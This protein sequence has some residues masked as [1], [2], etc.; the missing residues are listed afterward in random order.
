MYSGILQILN[1]YVQKCLEISVQSVYRRSA[2]YK[3]KS[4]DVNCAVNYFR[5][6]SGLKEQNI[7]FIGYKYIHFQSRTFLLIKILK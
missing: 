3:I 4:E 6:G 1:V 2:A 7:P 5:M